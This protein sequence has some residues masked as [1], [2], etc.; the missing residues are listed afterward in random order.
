[1]KYKLSPIG[2]FWYYAINLISF[3]SLYFMK[4][5]V[6]KALTEQEK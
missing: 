6:K 2:Y 4:I 1:M 3:G 5:A